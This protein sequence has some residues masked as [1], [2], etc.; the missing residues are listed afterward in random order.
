LTQLPGPNPFEENERAFIVALARLSAQALDRARLYEAQAEARR[1]AEEANE[2]KTKF[3][4][5][6][7]HELRTPLT[8][9]KGFTTTL[10]A[11]DIHWG[12]DEQNEFL[13]IIDSEAEKLKD[14]VEQLLDV[15]TLQAGTLR[16]YPSPQRLTDI[17]DI[18]RAQIVNLARD[19][20]LV[21]EIPDT[22]PPIL[23]D[24]QRLAQVIGNLVENAVKYSPEG[25]RLSISASQVGDAIR[26]DVSDEG[27]GIEPKDRDMIFE[28]FR[29]GQTA[30]K[31]A[32]LGLAICKGLVE[33][34]GGRIWVQG[35]DG[36]GATVSFTVPVALEPVSD[37]QSN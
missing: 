7:S 1:E 13:Q 17:I 24:S 32:G 4:A 26:I 28:A 15:S 9:I 29:Q 6:I 36:P 31:G 35:R 3:L 30:Q 27:V 37:Q 5:M 11:S 34:H 21:L 33:A 12:V 16:I 14:L 8:S 18:S 10:L 2:L 22:L 25:S 19:H 20:E 23:A